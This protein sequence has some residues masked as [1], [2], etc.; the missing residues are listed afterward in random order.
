MHGTQELQEFDSAL[1]N[2][3]SKSSQ[4]DSTL[5]GQLADDVAEGPGRTTASSFTAGDR[6]DASGLPGNRGTEGQGNTASHDSS[7]CTSRNTALSSESSNSSELDSSILDGQVIDWVVEGAGRA[8]TS[9][10]ASE[11]GMSSDLDPSCAGH[12][13]DGVAQAP[14]KTHASR[15]TAEDRVQASKP[16]VEPSAILANLPLCSRYVTLLKFCSAFLLVRSVS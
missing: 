7:S 4:L 9:I 11:S 14:G 16:A 1:G 2:E 10:L 6:V 5:V 8:G 13:A 3:S 12:L 15:S